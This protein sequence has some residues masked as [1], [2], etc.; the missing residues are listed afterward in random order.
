MQGKLGHIYGSRPS[1]QPGVKQEID[2]KVQTRIFT[3]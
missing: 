3:P 2:Q 1:P